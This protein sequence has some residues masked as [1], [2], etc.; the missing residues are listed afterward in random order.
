MGAKLIEPAVYEVITDAQQLT[1]IQG[2][3]NYQKP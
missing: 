1:N 3:E 2:V